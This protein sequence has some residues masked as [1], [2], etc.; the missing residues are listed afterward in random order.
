MQNFPSFIRNPTL[1]TT[2][3][4][5]EEVNS[6]L[7]ASHLQQPVHSLRAWFDGI[8]NQ[9]PFTKEKLI[10]PTQPKPKKEAK[11]PTSTEKNIQPVRSRIGEFKSY[12][13][14]KQKMG[15]TDKDVQESN[16]IFEHYLR[17]KNKRIEADSDSSDGEFEWQDVIGELD[18]GCF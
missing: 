9:A 17:K 10:R 1:K 15:L 16:I 18:V 7:S 5:R 4:R 13:W 3:E 12:Q 6:T 11:Q 8:D 2:K 14:L